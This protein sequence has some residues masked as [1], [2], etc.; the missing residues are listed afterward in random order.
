MEHAPFQ[1]CQLKPNG[2]NPIHHTQ[3]DGQSFTGAARPGA[4]QCNDRLEVRA[5]AAWLQVAYKCLTRRSDRPLV[6]HPRCYEPPGYTL[7]HAG[8]PSTG[9]SEIENQSFCRTQLFQCSVKQ[10][11]RRAASERVIEDNVAIIGG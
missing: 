5:V 11:D 8:V 3:T 1:P 6:R 4:D 7:K 9:A 10:E 2:P